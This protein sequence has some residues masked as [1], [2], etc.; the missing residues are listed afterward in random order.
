MVPAHLVIAFTVVC[1]SFKAKLSLINGN[2]ML[3]GIP[4]SPPKKISDKLSKVDRTKET[5]ATCAQ[6]VR[7][8]LSWLWGGGEYVPLS[9]SYHCVPSSLD[10]T[11]K[12]GYLPMNGQTGVKTL[13]SS[14]LQNA[15]GKN[16]HRKLH[17]QSRTRS[18]NASNTESYLQI[19]S[20]QIWKLE[21]KFYL[22]DLGK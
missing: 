9:W 15:G 12:Q 21:T 6:Q 4:P 11:S 1:V 7:A 3:M 8:L 14:N 2:N 16:H 19:Y 20:C 5:R 10:R 13:P 17:I 22:R 18:R